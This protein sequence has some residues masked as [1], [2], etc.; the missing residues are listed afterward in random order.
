MAESSKTRMR[1][2][3]SLLSV[4]VLACAKAQYGQ[5]YPGGYANPFPQYYNPYGGDYLRNF[6]LITSI[7]LPTKT[8]TSTTTTVTTCTASVVGACTGRRRRG[9]I[10]GDEEEH[11]IAP[12]AIQK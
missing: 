1:M 8:V 4:V 11:K 10:I 5:V 7:L 2:L 12:S 9:I 6:G 3:I